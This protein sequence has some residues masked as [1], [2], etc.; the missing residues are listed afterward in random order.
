MVFPEFQDSSTVDSRYPITFENLIPALLHRVPEF[1]KTRDPEDDKLPCMQLSAFALFIGGRIDQGME[2]DCVLERSFALLNAMGQSTDFRVVN[3]LTVCVL[4]TLTNH[5][6]WM[7][8]A[9][10]N[11]QGQALEALHEIERFWKGEG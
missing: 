5:A 10:Q 7:R 3:L 4:E 8:A 9:E 11:L 2:E 6:R 1:G